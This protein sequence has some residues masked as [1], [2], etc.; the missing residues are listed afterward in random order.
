MIVLQNCNTYDF[1]VNHVLVKKGAVYN[2]L[3]FI[4]TFPQE[5]YTEQCLFSPCLCPD[6]ESI[7]RY[8]CIIILSMLSL[9]LCIDPKLTVKIRRHMNVSYQ[10]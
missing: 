5:Q 7:F 1:V 6:R 9:Q 10:R 3:S 8:Y 4:P 2:I